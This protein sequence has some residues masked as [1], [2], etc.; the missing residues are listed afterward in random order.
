MNPL[1]MML[2]QMAQMAMQPA[3]ED[4]EEEEDN[5]WM[6]AKKNKRTLAEVST[7]NGDVG[8]MLGVV[9]PQDSPV[10]PPELVLSSQQ[11]KWPL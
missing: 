4:E 11:L 10:Q 1:M 7:G 5:S 8:Q 9:P 3:V 6:K 2:P